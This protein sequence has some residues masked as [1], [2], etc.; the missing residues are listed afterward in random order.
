MLLLPERPLMEPRVTTVYV[1]LSSHE[2]EEMFQTRSSSDASF[3]PVRRVLL[4]EERDR[5]DR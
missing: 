4:R 5:A 3:A 1:T 2:R